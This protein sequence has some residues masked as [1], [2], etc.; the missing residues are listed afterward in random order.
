MQGNVVGT[1]DLD[2]SSLF[3]NS[4][5]RHD[6]NPARY[7]EE[8]EEEEEEIEEIPKPQ[9]RGGRGGGRPGKEPAQTQYAPHL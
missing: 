9:P 4:N 3:L 7:V 5:A 6:L 2:L 1:L 8:S